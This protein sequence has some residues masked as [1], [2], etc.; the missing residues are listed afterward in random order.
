[1][2]ELLTVTEIAQLLRVSDRVVRSLIKDGD[3]VA[4]KIGREYRV[5]RSDVDRYLT[6]QSTSDEA[7]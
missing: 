1:M 6:K 2:D 3:L 4:V 5:K 7:E